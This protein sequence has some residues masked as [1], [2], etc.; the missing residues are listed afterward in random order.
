MTVYLS[1]LVANGGWNRSQ[2]FTTSGTWTRPANVN[3]CLV[4]LLGGG[5]SGGSGAYGTSNRTTGG[6]G[7]GGGSGELL[8][9]LVSVK[10][11]LT[12]T[13]GAGGAIPSI[14]TAGNNGSASTVT[15]TDV[16]LSASGG[17][18]GA[19]G[20]YLQHGGTA[21]HGR[22]GKGGTGGTNGANGSDGFL[23]A[24]SIAEWMESS[25]GEGGSSPLNNAYGRGGHGGKGTGNNDTSTVLGDCTAGTG[26]YCIIY[27]RE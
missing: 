27:W 5:A 12:V 15:G 17:I 26:G 6:G 21:Y 9:K 16:S 8:I 23:Q 20:D 14:N 11:N 7:G 10:S 13:L 2:E 24:T 1:N 22:G 19:V 18:G 3:E 4:V 25:G